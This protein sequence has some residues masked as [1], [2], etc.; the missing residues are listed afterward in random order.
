MSCIPWLSKL[1]SGV[2]DGVGDLEPDSGPNLVANSTTYTEPNPNT[3]VVNPELD[4][5]HGPEFTS[6]INTA[7]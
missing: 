2:G 6:V 4:S 3:T 1:Y 7:I 5:E